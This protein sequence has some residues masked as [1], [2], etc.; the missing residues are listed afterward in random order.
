MNAKTRFASALVAVFAAWLALA[1]TYAWMCNR[2]ARVRNCARTSRATG[3]Q[4]RL[5]GLPTGQ[6]PAQIREE[7][8]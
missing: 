5:A 7:L 8:N 4:R 2:E 6:Q 1:D 3:I